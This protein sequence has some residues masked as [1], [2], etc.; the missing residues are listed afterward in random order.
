MT[1]KETEIRDAAGLYALV[2]REMERC[3]ADRMRYNPREG[4][5]PFRGEV[6]LLSGMDPN[7][8]RALRLAERFLEERVIGPCPKLVADSLVYDNDYQKLAIF[9]TPDA[10]YEFFHGARID[11]VGR[12]IEGTGREPV[13]GT[14]IREISR[15]HLDALFRIPQ[16]LEEFWK[17][18]AAV[19]EPL[20]FHL[21][22]VRDFRL[23]AVA[24]AVDWN[25][26]PGGALATEH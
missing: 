18:V 15:A 12:I 20:G 14:L 8:R 17:E 16:L 5:T 22:R 13:D 23:L 2:D 11:D 6:P 26:E 1:S 19:V 3:G 4:F 10:I 25:F 9:P 24:A 7:T 21:Q